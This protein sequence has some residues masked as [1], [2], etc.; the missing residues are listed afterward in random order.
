MTINLYN[1]IKMSHTYQNFGKPPLK[2]YHSE[3]SFLSKKREPDNSYREK[4]RLEDDEPSERY[5]KAVDRFDKTEK[6]YD[7]IERYE[8]H[9]KYDKSDHFYSENEKYQSMLYLIKVK[10]RFK[11]LT[12]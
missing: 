9:D 8:K 10:N 3:S 5:E 2:N 11:L 7:K 6:Y 1:F 4:K 12:R